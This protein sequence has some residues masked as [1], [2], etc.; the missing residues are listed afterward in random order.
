M[1]YQPAKPIEP[2]CKAM[3]IGAERHTGT[4]V[5]VE[6]IAHEV[7]AGMQKK[8]GTWWMTDY[9]VWNRAHTKKVRWVPERNLIR[10]DDEDPDQTQEL[11]EEM[12]RK[13]LAGILD[14]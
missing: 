5:T 3:M 11:T 6:R 10:I 12:V 7:P 8:Y 2:G 13:N 14:G 1:D 4:I 9:E